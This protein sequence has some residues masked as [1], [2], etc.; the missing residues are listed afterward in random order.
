MSSRKEPGLDEPVL[1]A[2]GVAVARTDLETEALVEAS[3]RIEV[4][5]GDNKMV[6]A[7]GHA[8]LRLHIPS[9]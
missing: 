8:L 6:D 3:R 7:S 2:P 4:A 1:G 9:T 5:H